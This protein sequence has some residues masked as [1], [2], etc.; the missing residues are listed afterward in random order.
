MLRSMTP[1]QRRKAA[2]LLPAV[3]L[4]PKTCGKARAREASGSATTQLTLINARRTANNQA[5]YAG[6]T[7]AASVKT[8]LFN[9]RALEFYLEGK[10]LADFRRSPASTATTVTATGQPYFKPGYANTGS[11]TCYPLPRTE[12]DNNPNMAGK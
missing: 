10:R 2:R 3:S 12:R 11:Q 5:A 9:Q 1:P 7:D 8:E 6:A 4:V